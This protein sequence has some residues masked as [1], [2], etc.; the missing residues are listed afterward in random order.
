MTEL[1]ASMLLAPSPGVRA[2][3]S[4]LR[5]GRA[6]RIEARVALKALLAQT[7][8][9]ALDSAGAPRWVDSLLVRRHEHLPIAATA[10]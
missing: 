7:T 10:R 1:K 5:R 4:L 9:F 6:G 3:D 8:D 2:R